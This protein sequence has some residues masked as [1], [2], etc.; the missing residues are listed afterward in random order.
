MR[1]M[2]MRVV[3]GSALAGALALSACGDEAAPVDQ[4]VAQGGKAAGEVL[5]GTISDDMLPLDTL[6][7]QAPPAKIAPEE[8]GTAGDD[9]A[10]DDGAEAGSDNTEDSDAPADEAPAETNEAGGTT[11]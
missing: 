4:T 3:M 7:S 10:G 6:R 2:V 9:T 1:M 11:L 5:G 8:G